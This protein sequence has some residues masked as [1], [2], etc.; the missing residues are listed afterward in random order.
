[1]QCYSKDQWY[2]ACKSICDETSDWECKTIGTRTPQTT[3][4]SWSGDD[5][6]LT[7]RCNNP[8]VQCFA[9][10]ETSAYCSMQAEDGWDGRVLG[11]SVGEYI[12]EP[13]G[14]GEAVE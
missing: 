3:P 12:V 8:G 9:K 10:D 7:K 5:C 1:M 6:L 14:E 4:G 11:G 2:A 13:A